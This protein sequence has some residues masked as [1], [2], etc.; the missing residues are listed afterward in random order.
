MDKLVTGIL[1]DLLKLTNAIGYYGLSVVV[2]K[3]TPSV[4]LDPET[5][6]TPL[7]IAG[8]SIPEPMLSTF[9]IFFSFISK[10]SERVSRWWG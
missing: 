3:R 1:L 4:T 10:R 7:G 9:R 6:V 5:T 2:C 8:G